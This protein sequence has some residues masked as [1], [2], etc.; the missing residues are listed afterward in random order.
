M[1]PHHIF[2]VSLSLSLTLAITPGLAQ[3]KSVIAKTSDLSAALPAA[4]WRKVEASVDRGLE[5]LAKHQQPDGSFPSADAAQPAVTSLAIMAFLSR[6]HMPEAGR[7]RRQLAQ[8][9]DFVL[10]TQRSRGYFSLLPVNP[11][12][13]H[14]SPAQTVHY[15]HA[16]AG[17]MLGEVY[18][19]T[20]GERS[21]KIEAALNKALVYHREVQ[22]WEKSA[23]SDIGGWR[24]GYPE[25]TATASDMSVTGWALMF[26]RSARNAEFNV[27]KQYFDEGL[28]Y[29]ERCYEPDRALH[30]KGVFRYRPM[31]SAGPEETPSLSLANTSSA[32]LTLIL[33]G[34]HDQPGVAA[35][36]RWLR[37]RAYPSPWQASY[38][39]LSTYYSSQA[40][41]QVGG[42]TWIE[43]FPQIARHLLTEQDADGAWSKAVD[44]ERKFGPS[45]A[46]SLAILSLT[47]AYQLLPIYQR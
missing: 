14:L 41:A 7:Y 27:P 29:V 8:A 47:P 46:T 12:S 15:N 16:I 1:F 3:D 38:Y 2:L 37:S 23:P 22:T 19:M 44:N 13:S 32:M 10:S 35:G 17:L 40:I 28:A 33:G 18:G 36:V 39:Y 25:V 21:D 45:Y 43:L 9:I 11:P 5:W 34:R 26:F 24:Y 30:D 31:A 4:E 6:G 20:T 42:E